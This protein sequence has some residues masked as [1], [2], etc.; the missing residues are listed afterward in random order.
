MRPWDVPGPYSRPICRRI[1]EGAG[2]PR[3]MFGQPKMMVA[4][5]SQVNEFLNSPSYRDY[6][7][8]LRE[9]RGDWTR[10]GRIPPLRSP[11]ADIWLRNYLNVLWKVGSML[12]L[13]ALSRQLLHP[14]HLR[15]FT[16]PW[17]V[18]RT[19]RSYYLGSSALI[20]TG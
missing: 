2:V 10:R 20:R 19:K 12:G 5:L 6:L 18:E 13:K 14:F 4:V 8:W 9:H 17:A 1:V 16:Y 3:E 7:E 15:R 11:Y